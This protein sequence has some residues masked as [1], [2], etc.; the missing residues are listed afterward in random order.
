[1]I[2]IYHD[3]GLTCWRILISPTWQGREQTEVGTVSEF[4]EKDTSL[5]FRSNLLYQLPTTCRATRSHVV[6]DLGSYMVRD[7]RVVDG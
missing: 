5:I 4:P 6:R 1:M 7:H 3:P 2:L